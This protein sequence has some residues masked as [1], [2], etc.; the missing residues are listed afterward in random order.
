VPL[1]LRKLRRIL[2]SFDA[3]EDASR[4]K[5]SHTMFFRDVGGAV[6]SYPIPTHK[7]D[8][9]DCYV[10]G[11]RKRFKLTSADGVSDVEFFSRA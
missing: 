11:V 3:W 2:K 7:R 5:G 8:V 6:Y 1:P 10:R 9:N 4:G